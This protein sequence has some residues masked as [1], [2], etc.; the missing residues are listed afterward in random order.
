MLCPSQFVL[1]KLL[2]G[3]NKRKI[4]AINNE[5]RTAIEQIHHFKEVYD[6][7]VDKMF[8]IEN[9]IEHFYKLT[10]I[11]KKVSRCFPKI[12]TKLEQKWNKSVQFARI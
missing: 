11:L 4:E 8:L 5:A 9:F 6:C 1:Y 12:G 10:L 7:I 2:S 3:N